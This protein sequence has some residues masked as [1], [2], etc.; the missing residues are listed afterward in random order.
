MQ[1]Q[2]TFTPGKQGAF[3]HLALDIVHSRNILLVHLSSLGQD[4][5]V[6]SFFLE[7]QLPLLITLSVQTYVSMSDM[8]AE[9]VAYRFLVYLLVFIYIMRSKKDI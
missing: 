5:L 1:I 4:G 2:N 6:C 8:S 3:I 9:L 7:A